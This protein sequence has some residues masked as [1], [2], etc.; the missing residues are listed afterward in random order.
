MRS[1]SPTPAS[2]SWSASG[3]T[4]PRA[5]PPRRPACRCTSVAEA[6]KGA[7]VVAILVPDGPQAELFRD[8]VAPNLEPGAAVLFAHG[9]SV[10]YGRI[11]AARGR[12]T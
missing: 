1:I 10:H 6:V 11:D 4:A 9:F 8:E 5:Q 12:A 7:Q 2:R 3:P